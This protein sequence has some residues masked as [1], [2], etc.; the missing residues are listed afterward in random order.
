MNDQQLIEGIEPNPH[1][2]GITNARLKEAGVSIWALVGYF[3][4]GASEELAIST[5]RADYDL[6]EEEAELA[7]AYYKLHQHLF[8][9]RAEDERG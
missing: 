8:D 7:L 2:P 4:E 9:A 5:A 6:S 3:A 1:R